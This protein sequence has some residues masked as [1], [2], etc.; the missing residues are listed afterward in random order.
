MAALA[1]NTLLLV[2]SPTAVRVAESRA[3][4]VRLAMAPVAESLAL[5][6]VRTTFAPSNTA[7]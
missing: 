2:M 3:V 4:T 1:A 6:A 5:F 7:S